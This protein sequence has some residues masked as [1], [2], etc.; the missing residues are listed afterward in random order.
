GCPNAVGGGSGQ[1]LWYRMPS[2]AFFELCG[3]GVD[4]CN[5]LQGAYISGNNSATCDTG[6]GATSCLVGKFVDILATGTVGAGVGSGTGNKA[7]GVQ[8]IK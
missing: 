7:L 1:N 6:N 2:F 8:L 3:D 4:G 5:G